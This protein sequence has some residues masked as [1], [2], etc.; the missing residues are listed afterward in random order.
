MY[1]YSTGENQNVTFVEGVM[2]TMA[3]VGLLTGFTVAG[4]LLYNAEQMSVYQTSTAEGLCQD[5]LLKLRNVLYSVAFAL[6]SALVCSMFVPAVPLIA[7]VGLTG[8][9]ITACIYTVAPCLL[10]PSL[11]Q[12]S[13]APV[14]ATA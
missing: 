11:G 8:T 7:L 2:L 6:F 10:E 14:H 12:A 5:V 1:Y 13:H 4:L 9:A 3:V